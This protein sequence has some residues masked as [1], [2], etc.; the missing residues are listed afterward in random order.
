MQRE[1][2]AHVIW[3]VYLGAYYS[4]RSQIHSSNLKSVMMCYYSPQRRLVGYP[5]RVPRAPTSFN[6]MLAPGTLKVLT[7]L[8]W[9]AICTFLNRHHAGELRMT[10]K[11]RE[12]FDET[13]TVLKWERLSQARPTP[14]VIVMAER[15]LETRGRGH[16]P[17][18]SG[19]WT[20]RGR[21]I[22][23]TCA[24][25]YRSSRSQAD[26]EELPHILTQVKCGGFVFLWS[27]I[28][29]MVL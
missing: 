20:A 18:S 26:D 6:S 8:D 11:Y 28:D 1:G 2:V 10:E 3:H 12:R 7:N 29:D 9:Q 21:G 19:G 15:G 22:R 13:Q 4:R 24:R 14:V 16:S 17:A 27:E 5:R 25:E 23:P